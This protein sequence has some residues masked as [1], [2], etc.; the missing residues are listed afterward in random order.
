MLRL[1]ALF[2]FEAAAPIVG[3]FEMTG[4]RRTCL[5]AAQPNHYPILTWRKST[6]SGGGNECVEVAMWQSSLL[7]RDSADH[8][9]VVLKLSSSQWREFVQRIKSA[10]TGSS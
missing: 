3:N 2:V 10:G 5:M 6:A 8:S 4:E 9:G 7:V 1:V